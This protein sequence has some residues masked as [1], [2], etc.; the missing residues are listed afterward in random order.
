MPQLTAIPAKLIP[1]V[2][3][4]PDFI[5]KRLANSMLAIDPTVR[6]SMWWDVKR[7]KVTEI[8][9]L[10]GVVVALG[11]KHGVDC[12]ANR[13]VVELIKLL[14]PSYEKLID[15]VPPIEAKTLLKMV[16]EKL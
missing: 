6:S 1:Y 5:F 10:N 13:K 14:E 11:D 16:K 15:H 3:R 2:L 7:S 4:L 8:D 12:H 9:Y